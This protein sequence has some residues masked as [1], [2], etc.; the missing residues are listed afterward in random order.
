M[1]PMPPIRTDLEL[2][3]RDLDEVGLARF[4]GAAP[5]MI[6]PLRERLVEQAAGEAAHGCA[7]RDNGADPILTD[8]GANQ[9]VWNLLNKG[10]V[11]RDIVLNPAAQALIKH[12]LGEDILLFSCTA[13]IACKGGRAQS[14]HAD[15]LYAPQQTPYALM[16]NCLWM[17]DDFT[18]ENGATRIVPGTHRS[19]RYPD[20]GEAIETLPA[21]GPKGTIMVWDGRLW[22][23]T[24]VNRT[25]APRHGLLSAYCR[26]F[27]RQQENVSLSLSPEVL[28]TASDELKTLL[29][30]RTWMGLGSVDGVNHGE[31]KSRPST[32]T[33]ELTPPA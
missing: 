17:L 24:G 29:G 26:A 16:A 22:H 11:F 1:T 21:T 8:D 7:W 30:F 23:G 15:Q 3:M 32:F 6:E 20:G 13:N 28:A 31:L 18:E 25:D 19:D 2:A 14:I 9:R 12:L 33:G 10:Q 5:E 27:V 4:A